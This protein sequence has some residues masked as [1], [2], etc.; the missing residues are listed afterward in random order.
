MRLISK[1]SLCILATIGIALLAGCSMF[2]SE[3][4][5][6]PADLSLNEL[7]QR[8]QKASD[9]DHKYAKAETYVQKQML[10][11]KKTFGDPVQSIVEIKFKR[12]DMFKTTTLRDNQQVNSVIFNG[13]QAWLVNY[14]NRTV[15]PIEGVRFE[16]LKILFAMG[17]PGIRYTEIFK[18]IKLS[19]VRIDEIEYYKMVCTPPLKEQA[20]LTLYVGKNNFLTKSLETFETI[21]GEDLKY[22]ATMDTYAM[23]EGVMIAKESTTDLGGLKQ[24]YKV[25]YYKLNAKIDDDEFAPPQWE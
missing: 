12:P 22:T 24:N 10:E 17:R 4:E 2:S 23:Y 20:P 7:Q 9:P 3:P 19:Q 16:T 6:S 18:D 15:A 1:L 21:N 25:I 5:E 8:M 13:K 11:V 14:I